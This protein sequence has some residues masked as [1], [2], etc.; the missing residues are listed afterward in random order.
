MWRCRVAVLVVM[1]CILQIAPAQNYAMNATLQVEASVVSQ[2]PKIALKWPLRSDVGSYRIIKRAPNGT[3]TTMT[4]LGSTSGWE[5][6]EITPGQGYEYR[7]RATRVAGSS[8]PFAFGNVFTGIDLA[9]VE[10]KGRA[11]LVVEDRLEPLLLEDLRR[12]EQDVAASG[13]RVHRLVVGAADAPTAVRNRLRELVATWPTG[14]PGTVL[15]LGRVPQPY[16]GNIYPDG[17]PE[18]RG[19]WPTDAYYADLLGTW[20]DDLV[21]NIAAVRAENRNV[22]GDGKFDQS[23]LPATTQLMVGRVDLSRLPSFP[24][25]EEQLLRRYLT[26]AHAFR[27]GQLVVTRRAVVQDNFATTLL[28]APSASARSGV[29]AALGAQAVMDGEFVAGTVADS[30]LF[31]LAFG[32]GNYN[33][34][35]SVCTAEQCASTPP[36]VLFT[37]GFGSYFADTDSADNILRSILA[38]EG[39]TLAAAW[40]GRPQWQL[41]HLAMGYSF[42]YAARVSQNAASLAPYNTGYFPKSVHINLQGDPTL[43]LFPTAP[44]LTAS[45]DGATVHWTAGV[46]PARLGFAVY[47]R[48]QNDGAWQRQSAELIT[49]GSWTDLAPTGFD[50]YLVKSIRRET[51]ASGTYQT[52]SIGVLAEPGFPTVTVTAPQST[53]QEYPAVAAS[54][55]VSR[56]CLGGALEVAFANPSGTA[57]EGADYTNWPRQVTIPAG[58]FSVAVPLPVTADGLAE[59][60]ET[61]GIALAESPNY[62]QASG[63]AVVTVQDHPYEAWCRTHF[64]NSPNAAET[65]PTADPDQ[66]GNSNLMEFALNTDPRQPNAGVRNLT[67]SS[68]VGEAIATYSRRVGIPG[69][70][71]Q[72]ETSGDLSTWQTNPASV[73]ER[74]LTSDGASETVELRWHLMDPRSYL[75][76]RVQAAPGYFR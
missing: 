44:V 16:A 3:E 30:A 5:D 66:D 49:T 11:V 62:G 19:A 71:W 40:T 18:H 25:S 64:G 75:R 36:R 38:A 52:A 41:H 26:K 15:L 4:V 74:T 47:R 58:E 31:G 43:E 33:Y 10:D 14:T 1:G 61:I 63:T 56:N 2:P 70:T 72:C 20:T 17:H 53:A 22:V 37:L 24:Q 23:S 21:S 59:G 67:P 29:N 57:T 28:E 73:Q 13:Y 55:K 8:P 32:L 69:L 39:C 50:T 9:L 6:T 12:W 34:I 48:N 65:A 27:T 35:A 68:A 45:A 54:I 7:L 51:S 76:I 60:P 42:G 46:D